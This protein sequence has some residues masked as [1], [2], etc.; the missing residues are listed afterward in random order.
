M[1]IIPRFTAASSGDLTRL[2]G[3]VTLLPTLPA[4]PCNIQIN[5]YLLYLWAKSFD[6]NV[7]I[8][9]FLVKT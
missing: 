8:N 1:D 4:S 3:L 9:S 7:N 5:K 2:N 6:F